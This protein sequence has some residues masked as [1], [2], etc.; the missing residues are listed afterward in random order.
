MSALASRSLAWL[1]RLSVALYCGLVIGLSFT[2][3]LSIAHIYD[4]YATYHES[5]ARLAR[6]QDGAHTN[7]DAAPSGSPFLE[8]PS[9]T[10]ANATL[11][12]RVTSAIAAAGGNVVSSE[13][14]QGGAQ[15]KEGYLKVVSTLEIRQDALQRLLHDLEAGMPF[16]F[17]EQ[18]LAQST[19]SPPDNDRLRVRLAVSGLWRGGR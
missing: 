16:L 17:I 3:G 13:I 14:E 15:S 12:Q 6:L 18:L 2:I 9:A 19:T 8:G 4:S 5:T 10:V 1:P 11:L 7:N